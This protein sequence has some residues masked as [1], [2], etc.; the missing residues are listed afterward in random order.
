MIEPF[1]VPNTVLGVR[2]T[3]VNT[4]GVDILVGKGSKYTNTKGTGIM[5]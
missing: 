3:T 4:V 2:D 1:Y 5:C